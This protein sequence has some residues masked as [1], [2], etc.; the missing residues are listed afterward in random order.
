M[1]DEQLERLE[2]R[3]ADVERLVQGQQAQNATLDSRFDTIKKINDTRFD[4]IKRINDTRFDTI[5]SRFDTIKRIN[6][7]R[8]DTI[9]RINDTRFDT[10]NSDV[11]WAGLALLAIGVPSFVLILAIVLGLLG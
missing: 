3:V 5:D 11:S 8:F 10:I 1:T 2:R 4:T 7:T 9:E 6:D